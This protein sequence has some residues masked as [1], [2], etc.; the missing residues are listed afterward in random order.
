M[1]KQ[2]ITQLQAD[3]RIVEIELLFQTALNDLKE[4]QETDVDFEHLFSLVEI[5][6]KFYEPVKANDKRWMGYIEEILTFLSQSAED[7]EISIKQM[8]N[9]DRPMR[10]YQKAID[11]SSD[12]E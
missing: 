2:D 10:A 12:M 7:T 3:D 6:N 4:K 8:I 9:M 11:T 1:P 5:Y